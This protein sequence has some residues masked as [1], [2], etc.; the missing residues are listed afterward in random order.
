MVS[1]D[2]DTMHGDAYHHADPVID[3]ALEWFTLHNSGVT[4]DEQTRIAFDDW[5]NSKAE[6]ASAYDE[7]S[8]LWSCP[9]VVVASARLQPVPMSDV[10]R[11]KAP[12]AVPVS[13]PFRRYAMA[14]AACLV[15]AFALTQ[16]L[17]GLI[18]T[19]RADYQTGAG[20]T[21]NVT[22]PDG[23]VML[24][25]AESAVAL[26]F[27]GNR[28]GVKLLQGEAWFDVVHDEAKPFEVE[29]RYSTVHV[30]GTAFDL[31]VDD[32][33]DNLMLMRGAVDLRHDRRQVAPAHLLPGQMVRATDKDISA[34][35]SFADEDA[36][37]WR[38]GRIVF[39][40]K[41]LREA[42]GEIGRY[43]NQRVIVLNNSILE[44]PV[45]G[46]YRIDSAEDAIASIVAAAGGKASRLPG[47]F[48]IIR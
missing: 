23:S 30:T 41:P 46:N 9:E 33:E 18:I 20:Q 42:L 35:S 2:N 1:M 8:A 45:S 14:A 34:I 4:I 43:A 16:F 13:R 48:I 26:D 27:G 11:F 12:A 47:G 38:D 40:A 32:R 28:R 37:A 21:R 22:L 39:S 19:W 3:A 31:R 36:L 25:N 44:T 10:V 6:H 29:G 5:L 24:L 17:P 7:I 15:L